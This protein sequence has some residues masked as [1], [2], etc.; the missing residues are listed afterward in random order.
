MTW[1]IIG[2][3]VLGIMLDSDSGKFILGTGAAALGLLFLYWIFDAALF[4]TIAK[5]CAAIIVITVVCIIVAWIFDLC[6]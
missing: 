6:N 4:L 1:L 5:I 3:A 2:I